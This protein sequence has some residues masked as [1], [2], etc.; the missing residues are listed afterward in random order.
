M[1][2]VGAHDFGF[3]ATVFAVDAAGKHQSLRP[4]RR[5]ECQRGVDTAGQAWIGLAVQ[6]G[7][8]AQHQRGVGCAFGRMGQPIERI[9][10]DRDGDGDVDEHQRRQQEYDDA[11]P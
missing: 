6:V 9:A 3:D 10:P 7:A 4:A 8:I 1:H 5:G 2:R 11:D